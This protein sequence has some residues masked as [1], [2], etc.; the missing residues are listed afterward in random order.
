MKH[1][2]FL[3]LAACVLPALLAGCSRPLP[4]E[5]R[6]SAQTRPTLTAAQLAQIRPNEAGVV[7][8]FMYHDIGKPEQRLNR[9]VAAFRHD[10]ERLYQ[11]GYRP[12]LLEDYL[13][14]RMDLPAGKSPVILTFDDARG[15]Q[16]HTLKDG[17]LDP[18]CAIGI[19]QAFC[20]THPDFPLHA[21]FFVLPNRAFDQ[22]K[23]A[24][25]KLQALLAM[26]CEIGNHTVTHRSLRKLSDEE[27][28]EELATCVTRLHQMVPQAR[29]DTMALPY[30]IA[31][32]NRTLL[33]SGTYQGQ[34]YTN[35]AVLLVGAG[36]APSPVSPHFDPMRL[37]RI[38]TS[39]VRFGITYWLNELKRHPERRYISDGDPGTVTVP[40]AL[41]SSVDKR[42]LKG[43]PLRLYDPSR[44]EARR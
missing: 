36:P 19:L 40:R 13:D 34:S 39:E 3:A 12:V 43:I 9:S 23:L 38:V 6:A 30:G 37:P 33:A 1:H 10:L 11:E 18:N 5:P 2:P 31:P 15:S 17:T 14:N 27:V 44:D 16:F 21:T 29:V 7:P 35:R 25:Q 26:G 20:K 41:A 24:A 4:I 8:I 42:R 32:R 22:H 28:R